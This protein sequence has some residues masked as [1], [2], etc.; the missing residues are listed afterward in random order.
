[1]NGNKVISTAALAAFLAIAAFGLAAENIIE[2]LW[3]PEPVKI[4]GIA[5]D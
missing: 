3:T 5:Q 1:M 2:C 4:D